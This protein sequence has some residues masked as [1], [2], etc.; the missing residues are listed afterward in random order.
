MKI[1]TIINA[2]ESNF[3]SSFIHTAI[4]KYGIEFR[5]SIIAD[6]ESN[7]KELKSKVVNGESNDVHVGWKM[8]LEHIDMLEKYLSKINDAYQENFFIAPGNLKIYD[9]NQKL[10]ELETPTLKEF[11]I[12][13]I[14]GITLDTSKV[15]LTRAQ[16]V[17]KEAEVYMKKWSLGQVKFNQKSA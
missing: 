5:T 16:R 4:V 14:K 11:T 1:T 12:D 8:T 6:I 17:E 3:A 9:V 13:V 10:R 15:K 2:F 7:L